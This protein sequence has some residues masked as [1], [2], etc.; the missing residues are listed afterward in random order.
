MSIGYLFTLSSINKFYILVSLSI[1]FFNLL[2]SSYI[3]LLYLFVSYKCNLLNIFHFLLKDILKWCFPLMNSNYNYNLFTYSLTSLLQHDV[4][5]S[6][7]FPTSLIEES[8]LT[9]CARL[10]ITSFLSSSIISISWRLK[11]KEAR[12]L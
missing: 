12:Y 10:L 2:F 4:S 9:T 8:P 3:F 11:S 7:F 6:N 5:M 1:N